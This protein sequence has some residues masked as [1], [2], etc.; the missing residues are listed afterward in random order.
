MNHTFTN[1]NTWL[2]DFA[3]SFDVVCPKCSGHSKVFRSNNAPY[4]ARFACPN[5]GTSH[6]WKGSS[7]I[8]CRSAT[9]PKESV[10]CYGG[11]FDAYF[12]YPL[13]LSTSSC[14]NT[15]WAF[16]KE[17]LEFLVSYVEAKHRKSNPD[18]GGNKTLASRLPQWMISKK[19]RESVSKS[20]TKLTNKLHN[21]AQ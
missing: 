2:V 4:T 3:H 21:K 10:V 6:D 16:N 19:N 8:E 13:F 5:C 11:P 1:P 18:F 7:S 15:L 14:G 12:H 20:L 9:P 17:H